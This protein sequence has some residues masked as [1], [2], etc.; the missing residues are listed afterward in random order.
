MT[1]RYPWIGRA[2]GDNAITVWS[3]LLTLPFAVTVMA[4]YEFLHVGRPPFRAFLIALSVHVLLGGVLLAARWTVLRPGR[5]RHRA[6][7]ALLLFAAIGVVRPLLA[8][9]IA[10]QTGLMATPGD[11]LSR[12]TINVV[13]AVVLLPLIAVVV[14]ILRE[15]GEVQRRLIAARAAVEERR[16]DADRRVDVLRAEFTTTIAQRID[17]TMDTVGDGLGTADA[18]LLLRRIS[19]DVVRPMSHELFRDAETADADGSD[20]GD[21]PAGDATSAGIVRPVRL[22]ERLRKVASGLQPDPPIVIALVYLVFVFPH[23]LTTYGAA[24]AVIL[25]PVIGGIYLAGNAAT[26]SIGS[27]IGNA[28]WRITAIVTC[29]TAVALLAALESSAALSAFGH[30]A[31][32][33]WA[34]V[35][36]Y[37]FVAIVIAVIRSV[38]VQLHSDEDALAGSLRERVRV[39]SRAQRRL[40]DARLR[41][42]HVLHSAVQAELIAASLGLRSGAGPERDASAVVTETVAGIK[43]DLLARIREEPAPARAGIEAILTLW[44]SALRIEVGVEDDVWELLD[45]DPAR[46]ASVVDALSEGLTNAVRHGRGTA[47]DLRIIHDAERDLV[48]V[49]VRSEGPLGESPSSDPG[50]GLDALRRSA[51]AVSLRSDDEHVVLTVTVG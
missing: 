6:L 34:E 38:S 11:V 18:A 20:A 37:P 12:A 35:A 2:F 42:S 28:A 41:M 24:V 45:D 14:D 30:S 15:H 36:S 22:T 7:T 13:S 5:G 49:E 17:A 4:G 25:T 21:G 48:V 3:W 16:V 27:R 26:Y 47:V 9:A 39:A 33:Y 32:F 46:A 1:G 50:I 8:V 29:Y 51:S 23:L 43:T 10:A 19:D 40:A 44:G 31:Q